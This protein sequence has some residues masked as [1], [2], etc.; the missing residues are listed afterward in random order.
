MAF[1][2]TYVFSFAT[3]VCIVCSLAV[4]SVAISLEDL[5]VI[6]KERDRQSNILG[7]LGLEAEGEAIDAAWADHIEEVF[8]DGAGQTVA[9]VSFDQDGDGDLDKDDVLSGWKTANL[10]GGLPKVSSVYRRK[11][12]GAFAIPMYGKGLW[13]PI[14]GFLALDKLGGTVE[15]TTFFAP[16]ETPGLGAEILKDKFKALWIG[17]R[18]V[19]DAGQTQHIVVKKVCAVDETT[20]VDGVSGATITSNGVSNMARKSLDFYDPYL[21]SVRGGEQ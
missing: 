10:E 19:D 1:N 9:G 2:S 20:C 12:T 11:D 13:G 7:A 6:N 18:I 14:S 5:Q 3:G 21:Q 8:V 15:G 4:G 17:K 16:K